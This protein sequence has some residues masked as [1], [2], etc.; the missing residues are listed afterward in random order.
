M[1][2]THE[3]Y[4]A[5]RIKLMP[6]DVVKDEIP[7]DKADYGILM[8]VLSAIKPEKHKETIQKIADKMNKGA[9]LYFR[10]YARYDLAQLR[11]AQRK[12]NKVGGLNMSRFQNLLQSYSSQSSGTRA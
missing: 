2:K 10:D 7:F 11:F 3:L 8:F 9:I 5:K 4:D 6:L 12:K 1:A